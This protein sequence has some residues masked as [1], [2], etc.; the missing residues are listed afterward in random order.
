MLMVAVQGKGPGKGFAF[1]ERKIHVEETVT[2]RIRVIFCCVWDCE[3]QAQ[4]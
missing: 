3:I 1:S 2:K 4:F